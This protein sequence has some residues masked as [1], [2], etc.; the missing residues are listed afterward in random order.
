MTAQHREELVYNDQVYYLATEPL[1]PYLDK[2]KIKFKPNCSACWRG[3]I[4]KWIVENNK[5]YI[6]SLDANCSDDDSDEIWWL[7]NI[8]TVDLNYLFPNQNKVF[9]EWFSGEIRMPYG[10]LL[11]TSFIGYDAI[12]EKELILEF[13][14]GHLIKQREIDNNNQ[15]LWFNF[16]DNDIALKSGIYVFACAGD[17][18]ILFE[19]HR[20][21]KGEKLW[22][23]FEGDFEHYNG[24]AVVIPKAYH[25]ITEYVSISEEW[26]SCDSYF[27][28]SDHTKIIAYSIKDKIG[29][30]LAE[31]DSIIGSCGDLP[32][33]LENLSKE[34]FLAFRF[35]PMYMG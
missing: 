26:A 24:W 31:G 5:L 12:Y 7:D 9:A 33:E 30:L 17:N 22:K 13:E 3:Y 10:D 27:F 32:L 16:E 35:I 2:N 6:V 15:R 20:L 25:Y 8:Y 34:N 11:K 21:E 19:V 14:N 29:Y 28:N 18:H 23:Y 1:K 4:G